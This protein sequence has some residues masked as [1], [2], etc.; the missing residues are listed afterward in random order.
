MKMTPQDMLKAV[1]ALERE[2]GSLMKSAVSPMH[3]ADDE[4]EM[5]EDM[6]SDDVQP[7]DQDIDGIQDSEQQDQMAPDMAPQD[8]QAPE[9]QEPGEI[10]DSF[11][12]MLKEMDIEHLQELMGDIQAELAAR[13]PAPEAPV[14]PMA[15]PAPRADDMP[16]EEAEKS[17][18]MMKAAIDKMCKSVESIS[19][20]VQSLRKSAQAPVAPKRIARA[21]ATG[22]VEALEKSTPVAQ[23]LNKSET[24]EFLMSLQKSKSP[25]VNTSLITQVHGARSDEELHRLQDGLALKGVQVPKK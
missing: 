12:G 17:M 8:E 3:K 5:K 4:E 13:Q 21:A 25:H 10:E 18:R 19:S 24:V 16:V 22:P 1:D 15:P 7:D 6:M 11:H 14:S 20:E 23:R 9:G 2:I